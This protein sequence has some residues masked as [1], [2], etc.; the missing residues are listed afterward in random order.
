[1]PERPLNDV[2]EV[3]LDELHPDPGNPRRITAKRMALLERQVADDDFMRARPV[4]A[5][6]DGLIVAGEQRWR[7]RRRIG[8]MTCFA[9]FADGVST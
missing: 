6:P 9:Y 5:L 3:V 1:V 4:I 8:R 2:V 7:A